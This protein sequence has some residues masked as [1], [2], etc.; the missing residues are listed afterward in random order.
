M[1]SA[2]FSIA[3]VKINFIP[4]SCN[5]IANLIAVMM[6]INIWNISK[7]LI[8]YFINYIN[9]DSYNYCFRVYGFIIYNRLGFK[10]VW[11]L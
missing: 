9:L 7:Y 6:Q 3:D 8:V 4:S 2:I 11:S 10:I 1:L 5:L